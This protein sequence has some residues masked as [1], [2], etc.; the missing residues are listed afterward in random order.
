VIWTRLH[1]LGFQAKP[2]LR[3]QGVFSRR[4]RIPRLLWPLVLGLESLNKFW[5]RCFSSS[6]LIRTCSSLVICHCCLLLCHYEKYCNNMRTQ[7]MTRLHGRPKVHHINE[8]AANSDG[9]QVALK[10]VPCAFEQPAMPPATGPTQSTC[11]SDFLH[12]DVAICSVLPS[13]KTS[14]TSRPLRLKCPPPTITGP[15]V[16]PSSMP[17]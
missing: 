14:P 12:S 3:L 6:H 8:S 2:F 7:P 15:T 4:N 11:K 9:A 17:I 16:S 10:V 13:E 5:Y 1:P